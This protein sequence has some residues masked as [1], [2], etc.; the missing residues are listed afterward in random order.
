[1]A[2]ARRSALHERSQRRLAYFLGGM[3]GIAG[4]AAI[5]TFVVH[6]VAAVV[7]FAMASVSLLFAVAMSWALAANFVAAAV[8]QAVSLQAHVAVWYSSAE[9][10]A[11]LLPHPAVRTN[12]EP[13]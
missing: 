8:T 3:P 13:I 6:S 12:S 9:R 2:G 5:E 4:I 1:M 10:R 11:L 7:A